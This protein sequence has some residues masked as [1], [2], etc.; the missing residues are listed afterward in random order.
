MISESDN[1]ATNQLIDYLGYDDI[2]QA[3]TQL[4]YQQTVV[5]HKL[6]GDQVMP[7]NF[8]NGNNQTSTDEITAM[9]V[10]VYRSTAL[11]DQDI[12]K[13]LANQSDRELGYDALMTDSAKTDSTDS[14]ITRSTADSLPRAEI[15]WLGEKT[16]QNAQV[17]ASALVMKVG[18][19]DYVL[20]VAF[21]YNSD[22]YAMRQIIYGIANHLA[23]VGP[24]VQ[25]KPRTSHQKTA[26]EKK[27]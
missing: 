27:R 2:N 26:D 10:Q 4:G 3:L 20:T 25:P 13:A 1:I 5:G 15:K 21:D 7:A 8:G 9:M 17:L 14:S 18:Q 6:A 19:E 22:A 11:G 16:A 23:K 24:L 12:A